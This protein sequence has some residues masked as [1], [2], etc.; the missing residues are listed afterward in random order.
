M[1]SVRHDNIRNPTVSRTVSR[2]VALMY[3]PPTY[4]APGQEQMYSAQQQGGRRSDGL[5]CGGC[6]GLRWFMYVFLLILAAWVFFATAVFKEASGATGSG[7]KFV[8]RARAPSSDRIAWRP[9]AAA[10]APAG[11]NAKSALLWEELLQAQRS[12]KAAHDTFAAEQ[13]RSSA[14]ALAATRRANNVAIDAI[15]TEQQGTKRAVERLQEQV[16]RIRSKGRDSNTDPIAT[17]SSTQQGRA[18]TAPD[19]DFGSTGRGGATVLATITTMTTNPLVQTAGKKGDAAA[20]EAVQVVGRELGKTAAEAVTKARAAKKTTKEIG[21][22]VTLHSQ[23]KEKAKTLAADIES[24]E[25]DKKTAVE[26]AGDMKDTAVKEK[27]TPDALKDLAKATAMVAASAKSTNALA[28]GVRG[29]NTGSEPAPP[30]STSASKH[31]NAAMRAD[32]KCTPQPLQAITMIADDLIRGDDGLFPAVCNALR[33]SG[34]AC[35][36][37]SGWCGATA[38]H[39]SGGGSFD[40]AKLLEEARAPDSSPHVKRLVAILTDP[41][42]RKR[43]TERAVATAEAMKT[44]NWSAVS[45]LFRENEAQVA[46]AVQSVQDHATAAAATTQAP[47]SADDE[48]CRQ[49]APEC[50][51]ALNVRRRWGEGVAADYNQSTCCRTHPAI[52]EVMVDLM[53]A[54]NQASVPWFLESGSVLGIVR[55]NNTQ[56]PWETDGDIAVV[57]GERGEEDGS[58]ATNMIPV[59]K[60]ESFLTKDLVALLPGQWRVKQNHKDHGY[61]IQYQYSKYVCAGERK[62]K[63]QVGETKEQQQQQQQCAWSSQV[64]IFGYVWHAI[65]PERFIGGALRKNF[66]N[67]KW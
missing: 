48:Q 13:T 4:S 59:E 17:D 10:A 44:R 9:P 26:A 63:G 55:H 30:P 32:F 14:A 47:T 25:D 12:T 3:A 33:P 58:N 34:D 35:C 40:Y 52:R 67:P 16:A 49:R 66:N 18:L 5:R 20:K 57:F 56:V 65:M 39:C 29:E 53:G 6:L 61:C 50:V 45:S 64:D 46:A 11:P 1:L 8:H 28:A 31:W 37:P 38:A 21:A 54:L 22:A 60:I 43:L 15:V 19:V 2:P 7:G 27:K 51:S 62:K 42:E 23:L 41:E 36:S 24:A